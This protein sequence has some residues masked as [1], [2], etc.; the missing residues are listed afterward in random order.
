APYPWTSFGWSSTA[1]CA[2]WARSHHLPHHLPHLQRLPR[3]R[4]RR[5]R[6]AASNT[7]R[8]T[9][10]PVMG[11]ILDCR[12]FSGAPQERSACKCHSI[13]QGVLM[14]L[15]YC[16]SAALFFSPLPDAIARLQA[17]W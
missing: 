14:L 3:R 8:A 2:P 9:A 13:F 4:L 1:P 6:A 12:V 16:F 11:F 17:M 5:A 15:Q 10:G 7:D